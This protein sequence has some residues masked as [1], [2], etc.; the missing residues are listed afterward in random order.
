MYDGFSKSLDEY[1]IHK[2]LGAVG[3]L[4]SPKI[5]MGEGLLQQKT[6]GKHF[7]KHLAGNMMLVQPKHARKKQSMG[8]VLH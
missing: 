2:L 7:N 8:C 5:L 1:I 6:R 4:V 3:A